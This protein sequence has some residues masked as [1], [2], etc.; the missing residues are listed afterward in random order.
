MPK[1]IKVGVITQEDGAHLP[2]YFSA[3]AKTEEA[4]TVALADPSGKSV[5]IAR[6]LLRG[7]LHE[8]FK[9]PA[10]LLRRFDPGMVV[11]S[12]EAAAAPPVINAALDAGCHVF[13]E[14]PS[15]TRAED[16]EKL[17]RKAEMKHRHLMLALAN[18]PHPPV[19]EARRLIQAGKLGKIY[20]VEVHL[21]TDQTRLKGEEYRKKWFC[22]KARAGG[23]QLIWVGIHWLDMALYITGLKIKQVAGFAGLVGGQPI[24]IEDS[25][26]LSFRFDN[27]SFGTMTAG[28]YLDKGYQSHV[29][30]WGEHGWIKLAAVEEEP[31]EWYSSKD[32]KNAKVERFE[33]PKGER[34]YL[35]FLRSAV[36]ASAGLEDAPITGAEGL[37]VL[38]S[39]FAFY[40][41]AKTGRAQMV[42]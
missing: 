15:C 26:A 1:T 5:E 19:R 21:V 12:L 22:S 2:D 38:K 11:V 37:H 35:N 25:A 7:K 9:D 18:R 8:V 13:A 16:F 29:Q 31:M 23:G 24:D 41:A 27:G 33:F 6:T 40:E 28:Y 36:R 3:L 34:G 20:G 10:E 39:I 14:K 30:I 17:T 42:D 4:E 32:G